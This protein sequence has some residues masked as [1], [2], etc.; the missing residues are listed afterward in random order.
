MAAQTQQSSGDLQRVS[1]IANMVVGADPMSREVMVA[2]NEKLLAEAPCLRE[3]VRIAG[4]EGL[5]VHVAQ[6]TAGAKEPGYFS[7]GV[8]HFLH[9]HINRRKAQDLYSL[10]DNV[11]AEVFLRTGLQ[12]LIDSPNDLSTRVLEVSGDRLPKMFAD[13]CHLIAQIAVDLKACAA[14]INPLL[15]ACYLLANGEPVLTP[16]HCE[17]VRLCLKTVQPTLAKEL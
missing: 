12:F 17:V 3:S 7:L 6:I 4:S 16:T 9:A 10:A 8:L 15:K 14:A 11:N 5:T 13:V 2:L 1:G